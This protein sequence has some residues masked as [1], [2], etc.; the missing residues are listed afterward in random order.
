MTGLVKLNLYSTNTFCLSCRQTLSL[1]GDDFY[2]VIRN[3]PN[4]VCSTSML[5]SLFFYSSF[6]LGVVSAGATE[7]AAK[8]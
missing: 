6:W 1:F 5:F 2:G 8:R 7:I 4:F 3:L